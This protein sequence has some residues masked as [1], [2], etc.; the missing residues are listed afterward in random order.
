MQLQIVDDESSL[1]RT[2][3]TALE[4]MGHQ[5]SDVATRGQAEEYLGQNSIDLVFLDLRLARESGMDLI[6]GLLHLVPHLAIVV[7][8]AH[9]AIDTAVVAMQ[10]GAFDYLP[11]PFNRINSVWLSIDFGW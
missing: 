1:R 3:R 7:V 2:M 6:P 4:S 9:A 11:K 8:T 10:R 5:V